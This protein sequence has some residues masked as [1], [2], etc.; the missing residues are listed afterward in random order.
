M[1][2]FAKEKHRCGCPT[3]Y[4]RLIEACGLLARANHSRVVNGSYFVDTYCP[5]HAECAYI[6][7]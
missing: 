7:P 3:G 2:V 5:E 6:T 4:F 1:C